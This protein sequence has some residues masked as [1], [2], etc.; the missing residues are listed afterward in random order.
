MSARAIP[1]PARRGRDAVIVPVP[2]PAPSYGPDTPE[3]HDFYERLAVGL[4]QT[5]DRQ[6]E[7]RARFLI[8]AEALQP[9]LERAI[10]IAE[11]RRDEAN[12]A[13]EAVSL[14]KATPRPHTGLR[15]LQALER[16]AGERHAEAARLAECLQAEQWSDR[17][18]AAL[19]SG[20]TRVRSDLQRGNRQVGTAKFGV[21][22][23]YD[24]DGHAI[25][26]GKTTEGVS[27]R[28][29]RHLTNQRTDAVAMS[30]LD[31]LE[32]VEVEVWP[33]WPTNDEETEA[34][35][36]LVDGLEYAVEQDC[37]ANGWSLFN[38]KRIVKVDD[39]PPL[40]AS[41]R[42]EVL[43]AE[44]RNRLGHPDIRIARRLAISARLGSRI[45]ERS[46]K[47]VGL[48]RS[49]YRQLVRL[50]QLTDARFAALGGEAA[51]AE[52]RGADEEE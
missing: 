31:P 45:A 38:E 48:R 10:A 22:A 42:F 39:P 26:V 52:D 19:R 16:A 28:V 44:H 20:S 24:F 36:R 51:V 21:Y 6:E 1:P 2:D 23:F 14:L 12:A 46:L 32:V 30:V 43:S 35:Q 15:S 49:L 47:H 13:A 29:R 11:L 27:V 37:V 9:D 8:E 41:V 4:K 18:Q 5:L 34:A 40:P 25:Y 3:I 50:Q 17:R 33:L 7:H